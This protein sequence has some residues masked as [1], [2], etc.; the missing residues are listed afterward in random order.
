MRIHSAEVVP[1]INLVTE[2]RRTDAHSLPE[3][4]EVQNT[5]FVATVA[6]IIYTQ[7]AFIQAIRAKGSQIDTYL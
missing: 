5:Q 1:T 6:D 4:V 3:R 7:R 2:L